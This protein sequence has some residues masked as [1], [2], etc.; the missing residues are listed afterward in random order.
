M[1]ETVDAVLVL[2]LFVIPG[3]VAGRILSLAFPRVE[4]GEGR[5][6][7]EALALSCLNY[8]LL[9]WL[10]LLGWNQK[11]YER[12]SALATLAF[13][14]LF[15][16]P[17]LIGLAM[18]GL[19][20]AGWVRR[21]RARFGLAHPVPKA[22]D[23]FFRRRTPCWVIGTLKDGRIVAGLY[24]SNS[25][26]SSFPAE[27]DIYIER[28]CRLS[29]EG[30][31]IGLAD[32][33]LGAII[34][35]E[36]I[37]LLEFYELKGEVTRMSEEKRTETTAYVKEGYQ[38]ADILEKGY[39]P[40]GFVPPNPEPPHVGSAAVKPSGNSSGEKPPTNPNNG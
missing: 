8:G 35:M 33:S 40:I 39:K 25:F 11:W 26:A 21:L 10:L 27:E 15:V 14:V 18:I 7:L 36:N 24:G 1:P 34:R 12:T 20:D 23:Y 30:K 19:N 4:P 37:E 13:V 32:Q 2:I 29:E 22:W 5:M 9:S 17:I 38:V 6:V 3:F 28:L 16:S 31:I